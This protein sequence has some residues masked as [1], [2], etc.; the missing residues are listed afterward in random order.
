MLFRSVNG[1]NVDYVLS[2]T[3]QFDVGWMAI[4]FGTSMTDA[5]MVILW[6]N[7]DGTITLS[8]RSASA[9]IMPTVDA[10]PPQTATLA[11]SLS[12]T[13]G[14]TKSYA[15]SVPTENTSG[16]VSLVWA[17]SDNRPSS[18]AVDA[19]ITE[20]V[21]QGRL[22]LNLANT[23]TQTTP[24][25]TPNSGSNGNS[26]NSPS[27]GSNANTEP[28]TSRERMLVAHGIVLTVGFLAFLPFGSL[29]ARYMRTFSHHWF[30]GHMI[31][32]G[33]VAGPLIIAGFALA[34]SDSSEGPASDH[35]RGGIAIFA[36]YF[37]QVVLGWVIHK[38]KPSKPGRPPQNYFHAVLGLVII[39]FSF[40][41]VRNGFKEEWP[42]V[43]SR[44]EPKGAQIV[45]Y[46]WLAVFCVAYFAG[47][48]FLGKQFRQEKEF[49]QQK[50]EQ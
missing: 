7:S 21:S 24:G 14:D 33:V 37:L 11:P 17:F 6:E 42:R 50:Q 39:G 26:G 19:P 1:T 28:L 15:F 31:L 12:T 20:H 27:S 36:L 22:S 29:L 9:H 49:R 45:L 30:R 35:K 43:T 38:W 41:Q 46:V 23:I 25:T 44:E 4:G 8:Q 10:N 34:N 18:A 32:Q 16:T 2:S 5:A 48:A 40:Y 13:S 47:L 3:G